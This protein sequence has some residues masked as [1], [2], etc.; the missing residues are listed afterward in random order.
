MRHP[1]TRTAEQRADAVEFVRKLQQTHRAGDGQGRRG[2]RLL[3]PRA[4]D[5]ALRGGRRPGDLRRA[6]D[7]LHRLCLERLE[8]WPLSL[9]S[10]STHDTKRSEDV[11]LR[12][13]ALS[14][15]PDE[16]MALLRRLSRVNRR[17]RSEV[18]GE[19][20]PDR[21]EELFFYQTVV[22]ALP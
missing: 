7:D 1:E 2:H 22:G 8:R 19:V 15:I 12:I 6:P 16:W 13:S 18:D 4:A 11:R 17:H 21:T 14:E 5:L 9:N 20:C 3:P 10:T